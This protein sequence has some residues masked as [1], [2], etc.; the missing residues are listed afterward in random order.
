MARMDIV[1]LRGKRMRGWVIKEEN[2]RW[3]REKEVR[4]RGKKNGAIFA[5]CLV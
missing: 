4:Q 1:F 5:L 2:G 3:K